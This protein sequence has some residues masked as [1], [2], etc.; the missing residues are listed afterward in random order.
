[1][2]VV[3]AKQVADSLKV[4]FGSSARAGHGLVKLELDA[5]MNVDSAGKEV[6]SFA[7]GD[8]IYFRLHHDDTVQLARMAATHGDID[9]QGT[10]TR[11]IEEELLWVEEA[12]EHELS[13]VPFG[14]VSGFWFGNEGTGL[15]KSDTRRV[16]VTGGVFP[17][18]GL[19]SY[20]ADF[21]LYRLVA[22]DV[23]L[24]PDDTWPVRIVGYMEDV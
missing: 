24:G 5:K 15:K 13:Y 14:G 21:L 23:E 12:D 9:A 10:G 20:V 11:P 19:V 18:L 2:A 22:P 4:S 7:P 3:T 1:M 16:I 17:A 8:N 6:S